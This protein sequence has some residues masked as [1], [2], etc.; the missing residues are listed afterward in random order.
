MHSGAG[1]Q[2]GNSLYE[3]TSDRVFYP[4]E[5]S[6]DIHHR[7][8][9][10]ATCQID[11]HGEPVDRRRRR[12]APPSCPE[13]DGA[14]KSL[15]NSLLLRHKNMPKRVINDACRVSLMNQDFVFRSLP[16]NKQ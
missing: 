14:L 16:T 7:R 5:L 4:L 8:D 9:R 15:D 1:A 3:S 11:H 12:D 6:I 10:D 2:R 13:A